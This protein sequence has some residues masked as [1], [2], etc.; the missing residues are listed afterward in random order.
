MRFR[1]LLSLLSMVPAMI[2][3]QGQTINFTIQEAQ[4]YALENNKTYQNAKADVKLADARIKEAKGPGLPQL[5][6]TMDYMTNFGYEFLFDLGGEGSEPPQID[7]SKLDMGDLEVLKLI[8][9]MSS[10]GASTIKMTDQMSANLKVSQ[11]IFSG[12]YWV[13]IEMARLGREISEKGLNMTALDIKE[14]VIN[15]YYL[16]LVTNKLLDILEE[17]HENLDEVYR[18][19]EN[20]FKAGMA[21]KV[22]VDQIRVNI[23]QLENSR[24]AMERNLQLNYNMFRMLL[25]L[26][27][28]TEIVL[29]QGF[30][31]VLSETENNI[32]PAESFNIAS[33]PSYQIL[34]VQ[35]R[36]G[37]EQLNLQKWA[38]AP[39]LVGFYN[40]KK[41]ILTSGFDLSPNHAAGFTLSIPVFS[42][43]TKSAQ[44]SRAKIELD[45]TARTKSLMEDQLKLQKNQLTFNLNNSYE[46]YLTQKEN[47][48]VAKEVFNNIREKYEQGIISSLELT[49]A[50]GNY[51]QAENNYVS[52]VL[53]LLKSK[54]ALDKLYNN[55]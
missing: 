52:S 36:I 30:K 49:Q 8:Q 28:D 42:G 17:N 45:K 12:Q 46:N 39:T 20:M 3:A 51:L 27:S 14:Q 13:G 9:G 34:A 15:S 33:N 11:L 47:V 53:E 48:D 22:D 24:R 44:M 35:E 55:L 41:K 23:S 6:G 21:E 43:F 25:S 29:T 5:E 26:D 2:Y 18:H 4:E 7:Y 37:E 16:I 10:P 54:L 31:D 50:N 19:T 40:Y 1:M 32:L 38:Y